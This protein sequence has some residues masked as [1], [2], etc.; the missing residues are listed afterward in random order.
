MKTGRG[1]VFE[2]LRFYTHK[3]TKCWIT[4][5]KLKRIIEVMFE[6][7]GNHW[8][9]NKTALTKFSSQYRGLHFFK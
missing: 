8:E 6:E 9:K 3:E 1:S 7:G 5:K 2:T 4:C